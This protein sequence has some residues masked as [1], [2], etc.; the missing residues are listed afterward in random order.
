MNTE[1]RSRLAVALTWLAAVACL[2]A[3]VAV[4]TPRKVHVSRSRYNLR[5]LNLALLT[6][7]QDFEER[8][9][10]LRDIKDARARLEPYLPASRH[11]GPDRW[12]E[13]LYRR[14]Y[15]VN[16]ALNA[17]RMKSVSVPARVITF[18]ETYPWANQYRVVGFLDGH[19]KTVQEKDWPR[20]ALESGLAG[21]VHGPAVAPWWSPDR[22]GPREPFPTADLLLASAF[23]AMLSASYSGSIASGKRGISLHASALGQFIGFGGLLAVLPA[24]VRACANA[25]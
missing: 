22:G 20:V 4:T 6:Y 16:A 7:S 24:L 9:P 15:A 3:S 18:Y 21:E 12:R 2:V 14:P 17:Q 13:P 11:S 19:V 8:L 25:N 1:Q 23:G 10:P 5:Q